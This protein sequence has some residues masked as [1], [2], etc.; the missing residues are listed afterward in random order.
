MPQSQEAAGR[1]CRNAGAVFERCD[2]QTCWS[3]K[4]FRVA[5]GDD[6]VAVADY[7]I[8]GKRV[9]EGTFCA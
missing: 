4:A 2:G 3:L 8:F 7:E 1:F 6:L 9:G 5:V